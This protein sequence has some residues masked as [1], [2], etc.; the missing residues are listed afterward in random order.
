M[1]RA[2]KSLYKNF[3]VPG[4]SGDKTHH[5]FRGNSIYAKWI[6]RRN[7]LLRI[8]ST[9][10]AHAGVDDW[11][12]YV[13]PARL[14]ATIRAWIAFWQGVGEKPPKPTRWTAGTPSME[15]GSRHA[16]GPLWVR[17][18]K[19]RRGRPGK[20]PRKGLTREELDQILTQLNVQRVVVGH[21]P[22][23]EGEILTRH[24]YYDDRIVMTDTRLSD[25]EYGSLSSL[26]IRGEALSTHYAA[27]TKWAREIVKQEMTLLKNPGPPPLHTVTDLLASIN[28]KVFKL[29]DSLK[30]YF[31]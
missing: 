18:F 31:D 5:A 8:G 17:A 4:A 11:A 9:L 3:P 13:P 23:H 6:R 24:P 2:E 30:D 12:C 20:R 1:S 10:F 25:G 7:A 14:N 16:Q 19:I 27:P 29:M 28:R 26:E 22:V 21:S 15:R